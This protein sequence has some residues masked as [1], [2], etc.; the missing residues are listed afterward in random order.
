MAR[1]PFQLRTTPPD[2]AIYE[3]FRKWFTLISLAASILTF[4]INA[5]FG[6]FNTGSTRNLVPWFNSPRWMVDG[7]RSWMVMEIVSPIMFLVG[8]VKSPL[9]FYKVPL[10]SPFSPQGVIVILFLVHY[11][12][13]AII[14]P[15]RTPSRSKAH[16]FVPSMGVAFNIANGY[17]MGS[18]LSSPYAR[19][20]LGGAYAFDRPSFRIGVLLWFIGFIGN[21]AHDEILLD[22]RRKAQVKKDK[23]DGEKKKQQGEYYGIPTGLLYTYIS[24][25]NY[26]CEWIEW[27]GLAIAAAQVP[28]PI[29]YNAIQKAPTVAAAASLV[30]GPIKET[31]LPLLYPK[32]WVEIVRNPATSFAPLLSPPWIFLLNE[33]AVML[34][35]AVNGHAWYKQRFGQSYPKERKAVIPFLL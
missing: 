35:R 5:P 29:D 11:L 17:L 14:N 24:Y 26:F 31:L 8:L 15:L 16:L 3:E 1:D 4:F 32:T 25:P 33:I 6:R 9:S 18:Y 20:H 30:F 34:P 7:R 23:D 12:N 27:L 2:L 28:F 19:I 21:V 10:P 13:R 22:I